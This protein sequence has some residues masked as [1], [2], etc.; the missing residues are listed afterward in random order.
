MAKQ[1]VIRK[2][3]DKIVLSK[4][5]GE[6]IADIVIADSSRTTSVNLSVQADLDVEIKKKRQ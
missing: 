2:G 3:R 4:F 6:R 1:I 5:D